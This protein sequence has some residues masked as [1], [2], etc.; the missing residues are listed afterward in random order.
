MV[1]ACGRTEKSAPLPETNL[2]ARNAAIVEVKQK[3]DLLKQA[4]EPQTLALINH[5]D[6]RVRRAAM[7][8]LG[9][10]K[11]APEPAIDALLNSLKDKND[12]VR[13]EAAIALAGLKSEAAVRPL[14][15][16]LVDTNSKVRQWAY[17]GLKKLG[18]TAVPE[19]IRELGSSDDKELEE[20]IIDSLSEMGKDAV[21]HL[22]TAISKKQGKTARDA[23]ALLGKI[24][25]DAAEGIYVLLEIVNN[26][27]DI[28]LKKQAVI[29]IGDIGDV[30]PEVVPTLMNLTEDATGALAEEAKRAL[31]KLDENS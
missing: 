1:A 27:N 10:F 2:E 31:K 21:P 29:A 26:S 8:R 22:V 9:E 7:K 12:D 16:A 13:I 23:V 28:E 4:T 18:R 6:H 11:T 24:G 25:K 14:I 3:L 30:D 17:K 15:R 20:I 19:M 5:E